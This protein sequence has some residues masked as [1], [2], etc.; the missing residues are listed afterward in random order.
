MKNLILALRLVDRQR[1]LL[2]D[3]SDLLHDPRSFVEQREDFA[4]HCVDLPAAL[5]QL[6]HAHRFFDGKPLASSRARASS[7]CGSS[8][9]VVFCS[10]TRTN[11]L[12]TTTASAI[13]PTE[14]T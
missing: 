14:R 11:A 10:M 9:L 13:P 4:I 5:G 8:E 7:L 1:E 12:P 6:F 2:F 3:A